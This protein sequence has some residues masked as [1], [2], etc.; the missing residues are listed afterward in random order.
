V[1]RRDWTG[2]TVCLVLGVVVQLAAHV[3][4]G[5]LPWLSPG[6]QRAIEVAGL[7]ATI[8]GGKLGWSPLRLTG[9]EQPTD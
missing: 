8:L 4:E 9:N 2:W 5:Q 1:L 3:S 7:V 6:W